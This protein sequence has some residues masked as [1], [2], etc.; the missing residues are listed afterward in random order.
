MVDEHDVERVARAAERLPPAAPANL[1]T[2]YV[3]NLLET[4]LDYMMQTT[5]VVRAL[6]HFRTHRWDE[7]RTLDDLDAALARYADDQPGN[8]ALATHLWGNRHWTRAH[9]LR[10]LA[11]FF[12]SIDVVDAESLR[13]WAHE[14]EFQR[15]F[16]GRVKGLGPAVYQALVDATRRGHGQAGCAR[17][18]IRGRRASAAGSATPT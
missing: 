18:A 2:D 9:Q 13:S 7:I 17:A 15:D 16:K 6:E 5:S 14:S 1:E 12:R 11:A 3:V 10:D 8:T 4:V